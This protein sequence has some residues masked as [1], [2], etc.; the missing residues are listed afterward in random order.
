MRRVME[1][2]IFDYKNS[3]QKSLEVKE[4]Q[5]AKW[6][7][8][9]NV[10]L[11]N[12]IILNEERF[13]E[14]YD[15]YEYISNIGDGFYLRYINR[16]DPVY[17]KGTYLFSTHPFYMNYAHY[18]LQCFA[19]LLLAS[20]IGILSTNIK[21]ITDISTHFHKDLLSILNAYN[22]L[23]GTYINYE[24]ISLRENTIYSLE[25]C[26]YSE[27]SFKENFHH[28]TISE[29]EDIA[30]N[31]YSNDKRHK[32]YIS[33][34]KTKNR[35]CVNEDE[36]IQLVNKNEYKII[37]LDTMPVSKQVELYSSAESIIAPHGASGANL[38]YTLDNFGFIELFSENR[39]TSWYIGL[40]NQKN[41]R[42]SALVNYAKNKNIKDSPYIV[43]IDILEKILYEKENYSFVKQ[44]QF[45]NKSNNLNS[46]LS[47]IEK[48]IDY[49]SRIKYKYMLYTINHQYGKA[50]EFIYESEYAIQKIKKDLSSKISKYH[51]YIITSFRTIPKIK[52][53]R[54]IHDDIYETNLK[55]LLNPQ[56]MTISFLYE[57]TQYIN[58]IDIHGE[59]SFSNTLFAFPYIVNSNHSISI[60]ID[61]FFLCSQEDNTFTLLDI[62]SINTPSTD[63]RSRNIKFTFIE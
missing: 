27:F 5:E 28:S 53:N 51:N 39:L 6:Y 36:V 26:I 48:F 33:R 15:Y 54:L 22:K 24:F 32:F 44:R 62:K 11:L 12:R 17:L 21:I 63:T 45:S 29:F 57:E 37:E 49:G 58:A 41:C 56:D 7:I 25:K 4:Y 23:H 34:K 38:I 60:K 14:Y 20:K 2:T 43:D 46:I 9:D 61:E 1:F 59:C 19:P 16:D 31:F 18:T 35:S 3:Y 13:S 42:Y 10:V 52:N 40:L 8:Q 50:E 30:K 55:I 47:K